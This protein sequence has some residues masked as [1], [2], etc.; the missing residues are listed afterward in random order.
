MAAINTYTVRLERDETGYWIA[1]V[2]AVRGCHS[3]GRTLEEAKRRVREALALFVD[4][5]GRARLEEDIRLSSKAARLRKS[6]LTARQ[7]ADRES[8]KASAAARRAARAL[9]RDLRLGVRDTG[10]LLGVSH[11]RVHQLLE[12]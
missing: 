10:R 11:Q 9:T 7:R 2:P 1:T 6:A 12:E 8:V 3:H 4:G 5:A